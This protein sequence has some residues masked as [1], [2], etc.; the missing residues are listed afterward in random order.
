M[1][2]AVHPLCPSQCRTGLF[3]YIDHRDAAVTVDHQAA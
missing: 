3:R 2:R 1:N